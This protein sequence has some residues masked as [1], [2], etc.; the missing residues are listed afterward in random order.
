[1]T[2]AKRAPAQARDLCGQVMDKIRKQKQADLY[3]TISPAGESCANKEPIEHWD[4]VDQ[5]TTLAV[6]VKRLGV[7]S[8]LPAPVTHDVCWSQPAKRIP[9]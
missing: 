2:C 4:P 5:E 6:P 1:M 8:T 7:H 3:P 9:G